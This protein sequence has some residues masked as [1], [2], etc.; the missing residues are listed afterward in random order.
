MERLRTKLDMKKIS[1]ILGVKADS[2]MESDFLDL[3]VKDTLK[4]YI[5]PVP[6]K[7]LEENYD[8]FDWPSV[9]LKRALHVATDVEMEKLD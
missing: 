4:L 2:G 8:M 6:S 5:Q 3:Y 7:Y 9:F 1:L